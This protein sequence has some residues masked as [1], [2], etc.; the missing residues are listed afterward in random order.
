MDPEHVYRHVPET[1]AVFVPSLYDTI[2]IGLGID[3]EGYRLERTRHR[4]DHAVHELVLE[5]RIRIRI[6][7]YDRR[8]PP[9]ENQLFL[10]GRLPAEMR[11]VWPLYRTV[12]RRSKPEQANGI[13]GVLA[14]AG[15]TLK[16]DKVY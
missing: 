1:H 6:G 8:T 9:S 10:T 15:E 16:N 5:E 2:L 13:L 11:G 14:Y 4:F 3:P 7:F 12:E